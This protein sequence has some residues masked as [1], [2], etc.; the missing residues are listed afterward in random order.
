MTSLIALLLAPSF[1]PVEPDEVRLKID[2]TTRQALVYKS[3][4]APGQDGAPLVF[5]FHGHGGSMYNAARSFQMH[6]HWPEAV[7]VYMQ[8]L[9]TQSRLDPDGV[10]AGWQVLIDG[11]TDRDLK[12]FDAMLDK[13]R[14]DYKVDPSRIYAMGHS[15]GGRFTYVLWASRTEVFAA[16]GPSGSPASGLLFQMPAKPAFVIAGETDSIVPF[17]GQ[18]RTMDALK[19]KAK[20]GEEGKKSG[21]LTSNASASGNDLHTYIIPGGHAYPKQANPLMVEF[22]KQH[23]K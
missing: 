23:P 22:F 15:N 8:G 18:K 16:F 21:Y 2:G 1:L 5:G 4:K 19:S 9:P 7:V 12:F 20:C 11:K 6:T 3:S 10:R 13:V 17:E 14:R